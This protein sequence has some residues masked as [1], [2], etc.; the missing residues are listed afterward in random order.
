M[1]LPIFVILWYR[2]QQM[3]FLVIVL[4]EPIV[5]IPLY[6]KSAISLLQCPEFIR[7][8]VGSVHLLS[9]DMSN[10]MQALAFESVTATNDQLNIRIANHN[11]DHGTLNLYLHHSNSR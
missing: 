2:R 1:I 5:V 4:L 10:S 6:L 9:C 11:D 8:S 7:F 3:N